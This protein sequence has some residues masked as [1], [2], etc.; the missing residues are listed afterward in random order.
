MTEVASGTPSVTS[1]ILTA[2]Q[3]YDLLAREVACDP[4]KSY[5]SAVKKLGFWQGE[6]SKIAYRLSKMPQIQELVKKYEIDYQT[7]RSEAATGKIRGNGEAIGSITST[8]TDYDDPKAFFNDQLPGILKQLQQDKDP[9][10][11]L[12]FYLKFK[13]LEDESVGEYGDLGIVELI[14]E[15][16]KLHEELGQ[17][18]QEAESIHQQGAIS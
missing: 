16:K 11:F 6:P 18:I 2:D 5:T 10:M 4:K 1:P 8:K 3:K 15:A 13:K 9:K 17:F 14:G 12:D 7:Y